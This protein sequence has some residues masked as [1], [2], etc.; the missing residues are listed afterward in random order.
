MLSSNPRRDLVSVLLLVAA[1]GLPSAQVPAPP[2]Y[3][4]EGGAAFAWETRLG[5]EVTDSAAVVASEVRGG[6][7]HSLVRTN[8]LAELW[9]VVQHV[10]TGDVVAEVEYRPTEKRIDPV[11]LALSPDGLHA[12]VVASSRESIAGN[13]PSTMVLLD[14]S[15]DGSGSVAVADDVDL[16]GTNVTT[17]RHVDVAPDGSRVHAV[18]EGKFS[19]GVPFEILAYDAATGARLWSDSLGQSRIEQAVGASRLFVVAQTAPTKRVVS[20]DAGTGAVLWERDVPLDAFTALELAAD[21]SLLVAGG[22]LSSTPGVQFAAMAF[23]P[24]DGSTL[25]RTRDDCMHLELSADGSR[26]YRTSLGG[27]EVGALDGATGETVWKTG[28]SGPGAKIVLD[29]ELDEA[30]G[31]VVTAS[32]VATLT[33]RLTVQVAAFDAGDG[34]PQWKQSLLGNQ[35]VEQVARLHASPASVV[36]TGNRVDSQSFRSAVAIGLAPASGAIRWRYARF[37]EVGVDE[38]TSALAAAPDG[39][40]AFVMGAATFVGGLLGSALR[41]AIELAAVDPATGER[42]WST[43][44][45]ESTGAVGS[46]DTSPDGAVVFATYRIGGEDHLT[47]FA[48]SDGS[49]L[50]EQTFPGGFGDGIL[51]STVRV[52]AS[53]VEPVVFLARS[54]G[55]GAGVAIG[56]VLALDGASG[57]VLWETVLDQPSFA[58]RV[59]GVALSPDGSRLFVTAG[60]VVDP[61]LLPPQRVVAA[62]AAQDGSLEWLATPFETYTT[63]PA[64]GLEVSSDGDVVALL[65]GT[66][67]AGFLPVTQ[68]AAID[69]SSGGVLWTEETGDRR[70]ESLALSVDGTRLLTGGARFVSPLPPF[71]ASWELR[72]L[73][74]ATGGDQWTSAPVSAVEAGVDALAVG[75]DGNTVFA[76]G[77]RRPSGG[78]NALLTLAYDVA[79]G[80]ELWSAER[81]L[82]EARPFQEAVGERLVIATTDLDSG[83]L[84]SEMLVYAYDVPSLVTDRASLS[85]AVGGRVG[86][87]VRPG[88]GSAGDAYVL[89]GSASG[90]RPGSALPGGLVLPLEPDGYFALTRAAAPPLFDGFQGALDGLGKAAATLDL[91]AGSSPSLAGLTLHHA[92]VTLAGGAP[93]RVSNTV[94]LEL[95]P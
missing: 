32:S 65:A 34:A 30:S 67:E 8:S 26:V 68:L 50:W 60:T 20:Y 36:L 84:D 69:A 10:T 54:D 15:L 29:V 13:S 1:G 66:R 22:P 58:E 14:V 12:W 33:G 3:Q 4:L 46:L 48:A 57:A 62:Y 19:D 76:T 71:V 92:F 61:V 39:A 35:E 72:S 79:S 5:E 37:E 42:L 9:V 47:A 90:T 91:P 64:K 52:V 87:G 16:P 83:K 73:D 59:D 63:R 24:Q 81:Q 43:L 89:L 55:L 85:L 53:D 74:L 27:A 7:V 41:P 86:F 82:S 28:L 70:Y 75:L 40:R 80:E 17:A 23:D 21:E 11:D 44:I 49:V 51:A 77:S 18:A 95:R 93:D 25:W 31:R 38:V 94:Q 6:L 2:P 78:E 45:A 56:R 88:T